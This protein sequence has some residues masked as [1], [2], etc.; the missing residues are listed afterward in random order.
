MK[1]KGS[2]ALVTGA[3]R[4]LGRAFAEALVA[5]GAKVYA[6][7]RDPASVK[8]AGVTPMKL[9][10]TKAADIEAAAR[11]LGDVTLVINNAGIGRGAVAM[12]DN[13]IEAMRDEFETNVF[14]PL[15]VSRAFAPTLKKNGSGAIV[16]V[17]S[18]LAWINTGFASTYCVSKSAAW[19]LT[20]A[21]RNELQPQG[22]RVIG[23]HV[24]LMDTDMVR[25]L[26]APKTKPEIV[27]RQVLEAIE[28][29][30]DEVLADD[31]SRLVKKGLS[32]DPGVYLAPLVRPA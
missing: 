4:G 23:L 9:D 16:N 24:G 29:G 25:E 12:G 32:A 11:Q 15:L 27:A 28:D 26:T 6:G 1:I 14:G 3:N 17:L 19:G 21:L 18:V 13:G 8:I 7:A 2:V 22:T 20:N 31:V 30:R 10:V 5:Q